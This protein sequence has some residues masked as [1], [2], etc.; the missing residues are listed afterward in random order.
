MAVTVH[1]TGN[2][3][4]PEWS[5]IL[6]LAARGA[7][8]EVV[9]N[10]SLNVTPG[11][12]SRQVSVSAGDAMAAG[13][14]ASSDA[15]TVVTLAANA[16]GN[17]RIDYVVLEVTWSGNVGL[18]KAVQGTAAAKPVPPALTRTVGVAW[19]IPLARVT[20][21]SGAGVLPAS[22]IEQCQPRERQPKVYRTVPDV[23]SI[24]AESSGRTIANLDI[25]DPGWP[26]RLEVM[27]MV[28]FKQLDNLGRGRIVASVDG[29]DLTSGD[30]PRQNY[31]A[32]LLRPETSDVRTGQGAAV[33][34]RAVPIQM[35]EPLVTDTPNSGLTVVVIP[36]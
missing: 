35:S 29:D 11:A 14:L 4:A 12:G 31:G 19:Q 27:G 26:Y 25:P 1:A 28:T 2:I 8:Q 32:A 3:D 15:T 13:A 17:P 24:G 16:S 34:L 36:S 6:Q 10:G 30:A 22:A 5:R 33:R 18:I 7:W 20:V 9:S 21:A 23:A